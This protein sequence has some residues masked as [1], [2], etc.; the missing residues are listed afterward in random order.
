MNSHARQLIMPWARPCDLYSAPGRLLMKLAL[1]EAPETIPAA[2]D[3]RLGASTA[4]VKVDGGPIDRILR[5]FAERIRVVRVHTAA[6]AMMSRPGWGN[7]GYDDLEHAL[8]LSRTFRV[9]A[10]HSCCIADLLDALR[11]IDRVESAS[12]YYLCATPFLQAQPQMIDLEAAWRARHQIGA[13]EAMAYE[14]GDPAVIVAIVDTGVAIEHPE[15]QQRLRP[16]FDTVELGLR[17]LASGLQLLGDRTEADTDPSDEVGHGTSCAAI[18]GAAGK[19]MPPGLAGE[20]GML[21]VRVLGAAQIAGKEEPIG[22][23]ALSDIDA[24]MKTAIDL[25]AHV[26][27]MSFGTPEGALD[28]HDPVPHEDV[29]RYGLAR[30]CIMIAASGNSGKEERFS[31]A[32]LDGVIAVG[33]IDAQGRPSSFS[34]TGG[35]VALCAP[36]ERVVS[37]GLQD[38]QMVTGTSFAAPFVAATAALLVSRS[39]RRSRPLE[40]ET[41]KRILT[42][43]AQQ[44]PRAP[45]GYGVGI[46]DAHAALKKL[47]QEIDQSNSF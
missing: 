47:D 41:I 17:D 37:A 25:G 35:H 14:P 3:V 23:G 6:A 30:G 42:T 29:V 33:S 45:A 26:I 46:L 9:E 36:G 19:N 10:E 38:Y 21:P 40:A 18:I 34:T 28:E 39:R 32:S 22:I 2:R 4:A 7:R 27:N 15:L 8:G 31:P 5:K 44:W 20:C 16:G 11:Q 12:P 1:G 13:A 43:S 24:G